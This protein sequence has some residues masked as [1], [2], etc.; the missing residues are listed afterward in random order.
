MGTHGIDGH[1][2]KTEYRRVKQCQFLFE[3]ISKASTKSSLPNKNI[4]EGNP[5]SD[6]YSDPFSA[7]YSNVGDYKK[8]SIDDQ[9]N[10]DDDDE[11]EDGGDLSEKFKKM[12]ETRIQKQQIVPVLIDPNKKKS[13]NEENERKKDDDFKEKIVTKAVNET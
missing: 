2:A 4:G 10:K 6:N 8:E 7:A 1:S 12:M 11:N 5:Y 13:E 9:D 3:L